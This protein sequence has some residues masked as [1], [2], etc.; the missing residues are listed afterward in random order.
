MGE[1]IF[2]E[3]LNNMY[4]STS[5]RVKREKEKNEP[6]LLYL[7]DENSSLPNTRARE[8]LGKN[9]SIHQL[10]RLAPRASSRFKFLFF[11]FFFP[12]FHVSRQFAHWLGR[13]ES[14]IRG[15]NGRRDTR[16]WLAWKRRDPGW[17][18]IKHTFIT[19]RLH[20]LEGFTRA[21]RSLPPPPSS[22]EPRRFNAIVSWIIEKKRLSGSINNRPTRLSRRTLDDDDR[23]GLSVCPLRSQTDLVGNS[24]TQ[25]LLKYL[26]DRA[27][28]LPWDN[29][30]LQ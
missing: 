16:R 9:P 25:W 12:L 20:I 11:F 14:Q 21:A 3:S 28:H 30:F 7:I 15:I 10:Y 23:R 5:I 26:N 2:H 1:W 4:K 8:K 24:L 6:S 19:R 22:R 13:G 29:T 18:F 17:L 27:R